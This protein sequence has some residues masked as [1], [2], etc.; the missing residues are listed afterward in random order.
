MR[1]AIA[2]A[3][4]L[5]VLGVGLTPVVGGA[6]TG[7]SPSPSGL[8]GCPASG[9]VSANY[10]PAPNGQASAP[11]PV[12]PNGATGLSS[13]VAAVTAH[14]IPSTTVSVVVSSGDLIVVTAEAVNF[15]PGS[16]GGINNSGEPVLTVSDSVGSLY[17]VGSY[18]GYTHI[19]SGVLVTHAL[20]GTFGTQ[21]N[22]TWVTWGGAAGGSGS[23]SVTVT[24]QNPAPDTSTGTP[25]FTEPQVLVTVYPAGYAPIFGGWQDIWTGLAPTNSQ[26]V[27]NVSTYG[28]C[29]D[30]LAEGMAANGFAGNWAVSTSSVD[31]GL[32]TNFT[33]IDIATGASLGMV[34]EATGHMGVHDLASSESG[35]LPAVETFNSWSGYTGGGSPEATYV[36]YILPSSSI[37]SGFEMVAVGSDLSAY[38]LGG[39][40]NG[41]T[42]ETLS[43]TNPTPP[44]GKV[45]VNDTVYLYTGSGTLIQAISTDGPATGVTVSGLL[46]GG[47][48]WFQVQPWWTGAIPGGL[49]GA[50]AFI[51]G[52]FAGT[53]SA[54]TAAAFLGLTPV[55]MAAV[56]ALAVVGTAVAFV[57]MRGHH[58]GRTVGGRRRR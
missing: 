12:V 48:Y 18:S 16:A 9:P 27:A 42:S 49:S 45:L 54:P 55:D 28:L 57:G 5:L 20:T 29:A 58:R 25:G 47:S 39:S 24:L 6:T 56:A 41:C 17:V 30:L 46:C 15:A 53:A 40:P 10:G 4:A 13:V 2:V 11:P 52:Q 43:W 38:G 3:A 8:G 34:D 22:L 23:D 33:P 1:A 14:P 50:L 21:E 7:T 44:Q 35:P 31:Y 26:P 19:F 37:E 32:N 36:G 51:A